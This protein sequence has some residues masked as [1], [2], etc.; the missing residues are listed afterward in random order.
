MLTILVKLA[1]IF[2][3]PSPVQTVQRSRGAGD[4]RRSRRGHDASLQCR[5]RGWG[6]MWMASKVRATEGTFVSRVSVLC[7]TVR[8]LNATS[9]AHN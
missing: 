2:S 8:E 7:M 6:V 5:R 4:R 1:R 3:R 9:V